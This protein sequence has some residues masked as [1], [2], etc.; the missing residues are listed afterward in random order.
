MSKATKIWL[1]T[2][3]ALVLVGALIFGGAMAMLNWDISKLSTGN[4]ETNE[5]MVVGEYKNIKINTETADIVFLP[6]DDEKTSVICYEIQSAKHSVEVKD[7]TLVIKLDD[8]RKWYEHIGINFTKPKITVYL[9][10]GEHGELFLRSTTGNTDITKHFK[11]ESIDI[12]Q[13][14]GNVKSFA[15]TSG[16]VKI[17]TTTGSISLNGATAGSLD[18]SVSTGSVSLSAIRCGDIKI[19]VSTGRTTLNDVECKNLT[20]EGSTG[21]ISLNSVIAEG[22]MSIQ[23]TTGRIHFA[24]CDAGELFVKTST[25][26]VTGTL[27]SEKIFVVNTSTGR[28]DLPP[29]RGGGKCEISTSTGD[30]IIKLDTVIPLD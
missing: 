27:L 29:T 13:T 20:S 8:Q 30:I 12:D 26:D 4:F 14:T 25:G 6:S 16:S 1:I 24:A 10:A 11:F 22:K 5:H 9:P 3:G 23:R 18:L 19:G 2:A 15:S 21:N 7:G 28:I 17:K